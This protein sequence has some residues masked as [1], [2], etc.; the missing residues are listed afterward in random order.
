[1][2]TARDAARETPREV[3]LP[4]EIGET[5]RIIEEFNKKFL[6]LERERNKLRIAERDA[7]AIL[8]KAYQ[9]RRD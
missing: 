8:A 7:K 2:V 1:M 3:V 6:S 5:A 9:T 4:P